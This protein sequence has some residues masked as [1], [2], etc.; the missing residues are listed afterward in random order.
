MADDHDEDTLFIQ[1]LN[2]RHILGVHN[3]CDR[4]CERCPFADRCLVNAS[5]DPDEPPQ[6]DDGDPLVMHLRERFGAV[7]AALDRRWTGWEIPDDLG[8]GEHDP[9][10]ALKEE[11][12]REACRNHPIVRSAHAYRSIAD[13]WFEA[14]SERLRADADALVARADTEPVN[15][16]PSPSEM[17]AVLSAIEAVRH[18]QYLIAA[19][20]YRAL[21]GRDDAGRPDCVDPIQNDHNGSAKVALLSIDRSEAAWCIIEGWWAGTA[22]LLAAHLAELRVAVEREFPDARR[23]LRTGF[24]GVVIDE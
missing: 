22:S 18:D 1:T 11:R 17:S 5:R 6:E 14:E 24:D 15:D 21:H 13:A 9:L 7:R 12:H 20:L 3:Y 23:F 19:K 8:G 16:L 4:W 2:P 10:D